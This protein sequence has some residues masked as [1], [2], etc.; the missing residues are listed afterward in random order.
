MKCLTEPSG[1]SVKVNGCSCYWWWYFCATACVASVSASHYLKFIIWS[2][3]VKKSNRKCPSC[4]KLYDTDS[5]RRWRAAWDGASGKA[6]WRGSFSWGSEDGWRGE[7][8]RA[9]WTG[10][11]TWV[12][13][14]QPEWVCLLGGVEDE[15]S[16]W[17]LAWAIGQAVMLDVV[18]SLQPLFLQPPSA[19][20]APDHPS[21][22]ISCIANEL[23]CV[24]LPRE[25]TVMVIRRTVG[26]HW[27]LPVCQY[28]CWAFHSRYFI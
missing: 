2:L 7:A 15:V 8:V 20:W 9:R 21:G 17:S 10:V 19:G 16:A 27:A 13:A 3:T 26:V 5:E 24:T 22:L 14:W 25:Q 28:P 23:S 4:A 11:L 12:R 18:T 1:C 6:S